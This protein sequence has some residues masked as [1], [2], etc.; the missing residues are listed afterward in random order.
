MSILQRVEMQYL[1]TSNVILQYLC[2]GKS[3]KMF[4]DLNTSNVIL[5]SCTPSYL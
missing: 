3:K 1:N 4:H 2:C 5:Q